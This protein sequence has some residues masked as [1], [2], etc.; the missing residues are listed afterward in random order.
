M[1]NWSN[2]LVERHSWASLGKGL[3]CGNHALQMFR[4]SIPAQTRLLDLKGLTFQL[5]ELRHHP[6]AFLRILLRML[7]NPL[8]QFR[9]PSLLFAETGYS[10]PQRVNKG[11]IALQLEVH[12]CP[13]PNR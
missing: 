12:G 3:I 10:Y 5:I 8:K 11:V 1:G 9:N 2:N 13:I 6:P 7:L 4:S